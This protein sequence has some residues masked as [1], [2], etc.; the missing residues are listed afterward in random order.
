MLGFATPVWDI[1]IFILISAV[2]LD[3][4]LTEPGHLKL[5]AENL[6]GI[7]WRLEERVLEN[8]K[9]FSRLQN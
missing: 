2:K 9:K 1:W 4:K 7:F 8:Q 5:L 3:T 6:L